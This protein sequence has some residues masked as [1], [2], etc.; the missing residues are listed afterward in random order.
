M[1]RNTRRRHT[2]DEDPSDAGRGFKGTMPAFLRPESNEPTAQNDLLPDW[3]RP[4]DDW[5]EEYDLAAG[6]IQLRGLAVPGA[7]GTD[8]PCALRLKLPGPEG[9]ARR[10][11]PGTTHD[12]RAWVLAPYLFLPRAEGGWNVTVRHTS[13]R[14][15]TVAD[16]G[17][18]V[19]LRR[20]DHWSTLLAVVEHGAGERL[21]EPPLLGRALGLTRRVFD[22]RWP[23]GPPIARLPDEY[24]QPK[25]AT[26][27]PKRPQAA[28]GAPRR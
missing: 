12:D 24:G 16:T 4:P 28:R 23:A 7:P 17:A 20:N 5:R 18:R 10:V 22:A 26:P 15:G 11:E 8:N 1:H 2:R 9:A 25:K 14:V 13:R 21:L 27:A 19:E 6:R 3:T